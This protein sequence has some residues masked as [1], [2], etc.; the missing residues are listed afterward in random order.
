MSGRT[1]L[2]GLTR[3]GSEPC[4]CESS[5]GDGRCAGHLHFPS[6]LSPLARIH[7]HLSG[8]G[9][10]LLGSCQSCIQLWEPSFICHLQVTTLSVPLLCL[11]LAWCQA[12]LSCSWS[13]TLICTLS[14]ILRRLSA[15]LRV[16]LRCTREDRVRRRSGLSPLSKR[17]SL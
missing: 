12:P 5:L 3:A 4:L 8:G 2:W 9:L 10:Y 11:L 16:P 14:G 13:P 15:Q 7:I 17:T 6:F 1:G